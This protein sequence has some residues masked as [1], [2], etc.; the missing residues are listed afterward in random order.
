MGTEY[1]PD[2]IRPAIQPI[3]SSGMDNDS[4]CLSYYKHAVEA[5]L[6]SDD[7][8]GF[9]LQDAPVLLVSR[10]VGPFPKG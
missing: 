6:L 9:E 4:L 7:N 1:F 10:A 5:N 3:P 2:S 8:V